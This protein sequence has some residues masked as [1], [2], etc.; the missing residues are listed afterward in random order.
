MRRPTGTTA[1]IFIAGIAGGA[2]EVVWV[3]LFCLASPL[4][5]SLVAAEITRSFLPQA[6]G[7]SAVVAGLIIH[8]VLAVLVAAIFAMTLLRLLRNRTDIL[9]KL[10]VAMVTLFAIWTMNFFVFLPA[11]NPVFVTLMPYSVTL[12]SKLAFGIAMGW[13]FGVRPAIVD[14]NGRFSPRQ[15]RVRD[16][17]AL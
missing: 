7:T 17:P 16:L 12:I 10:S 14:R 8:F 13:V 1:T 2:A 6:A 9:G 5:S 4:Q 11:I 15:Q 3:G